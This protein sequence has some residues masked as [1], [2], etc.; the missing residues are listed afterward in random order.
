VDLTQVATLTGIVVAVVTFPISIWRFNKDV[1]NHIDK[2][3]DDPKVGMNARLDH[4]KEDLC[5]DIREMKGAQVSLARKLDANIKL[6]TAQA[7]EGF[8]R[9]SAV[10]AILK[11][12]PEKIMSDNAN[13]VMNIDEIH[14]DLGNNLK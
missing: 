1:K 2:R 3:F 8:S 11:V 12:K 9:L 10:E 6:T 4:V 14:D 7:L 5:K 13:A